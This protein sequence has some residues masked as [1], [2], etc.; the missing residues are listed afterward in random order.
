MNDC[1][2]CDHSRDSGQCLKDN[3]QIFTPKQTVKPGLVIS[4][5]IYQSFDDDCPDFKLLDNGSDRHC[6]I[7]ESSIEL[8]KGD[9]Q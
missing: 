8:K 4:D 6:D 1:S 9:D 3:R 7:L 5:L 2:T